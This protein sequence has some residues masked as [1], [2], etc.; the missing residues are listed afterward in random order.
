ML[1]R[2]TQTGLQDK[3]TGKRGRAVIPG[4]G[5]TSRVLVLGEHRAAGAA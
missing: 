5:G 3:F 4:V 1:P 2:F